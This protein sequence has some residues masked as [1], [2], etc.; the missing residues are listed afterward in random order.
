MD[1]VFIHRNSGASTSGSIDT[2]TEIFMEVLQK[3]MDFY[4]AVTRVGLYFSF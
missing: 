4:F 2:D 3:A 1:L